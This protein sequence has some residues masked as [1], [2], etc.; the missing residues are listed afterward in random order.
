[1]NPVI[2]RWLAISAGVLTCAGTLALG[3]WQLQRADEKLAAAALLQ[4]RSMAP[5]WG[6]ADWPC[7][8][9]DFARAGERMPAA[10]TSPSTAAST[11][12]H[13]PSTDEL[14]VQRPAQ[15]RGRWLRDRTVFLDNRPMDGRTGFIVLTPLQLS[16]GPCRGELV[17]VQR[18]WAPR[19]G[20][21]RQKLPAWQD[22]PAEV[23][24]SGRVAQ[25]PSRTYAVGEEAMPAPGQTRVIRQNVDAA[26]WAAWLGQAPLA[27]ALL[28]IDDVHAV[29]GPE[30]EPNLLRHWAPPDLGVGKHQAYAAQW[31]ALAALAAGLTLW[32]QVIRPRNLLRSEPP[33]P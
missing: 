15:L 30:D 8:V 2:M 22:T 33:R 21:D 27:G 20:I 19:D 1:M 6:D 11:A 25:Q 24:V 31:F 10:P 28:Q 29:D 32:F 23:R 5:A 18:G 26:F 12:A 16:E 14:P 17:L 4:Q 3:R 13:G 9:R 7:A